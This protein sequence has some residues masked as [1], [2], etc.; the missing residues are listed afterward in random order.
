MGR[1]EAALLSGTE[2]VATEL[3]QTGRGT[4]T[5]EL[6]KA[7][8]ELKEGKLPNAGWRNTSYVRGEKRTEAPSEARKAAQLESE[9]RTNCDDRVTKVRLFTEFNGRGAHFRLPP[10]EV[11]QSRGQRPSSRPSLWREVLARQLAPLPGQGGR[12]RPS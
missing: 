6:A 12:G 4:K 7:S 8:E 5:R 11:W 3:D 9:L 1:A 2:A 10:S